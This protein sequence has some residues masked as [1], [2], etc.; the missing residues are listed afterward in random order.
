MDLEFL[1]VRDAARRLHVHEN[2]VRNMVDRGELQDYR[3]PGSRFMRLSADEVDQLAAMRT[4]PNSSILSRRRVLNPELVDAS[5]L[6]KWPETQQRDAQGKL[7]ELVRRLL[8]ETPGITNISIRSGDGIAQPGYDGTADSAGAAFLP[9]GRLVFEFSTNHNTSGK[10]TGDY[11]SRVENGS[12]SIADTFI[13]V[14]PRRWGGKTQWAAERKQQG[15][16]ADVKVIDADDLEGWLQTAPAAHHWISEELGLHPRDAISL[17][18]WW[19]RFAGQ[20]NPELPPDL[21]LA[22]RE[23]Q[24]MELRQRLT[25]SATVTAIEA[26]WDE[27]CLAFLHAAFADIQSGLAI[28]PALVVTSRQA[29]EDIVEQRGNA[30]LIQRFDDADVARATAAGHHV[31]SIIDNSA[32]SSRRP[33]ISLPKLGRGPVANALRSAG[34]E[35]SRA[36]RLAALSR[37]SLPALRRELSPN[38][39]ISRPDWSRAPDGPILAALLL[40]GQWT[41]DPADIETLEALTGHP[42]EK[43]GLLFQRMTDSEDPVL[44]KVSGI[45]S[46]AWPEESF[47]LLQPSITDN[48]LRRFGEISVREL[49]EPS[50]PDKGRADGTLNHPRKTCLRRGLAQGLALLGAFGARSHLKDGTTAS[51]FAEHTVDELLA[52]AHEDDTGE[53]WQRLAEVLPLLAEAAPDVFAEVLED[54]L[55]ATESSLARLFAGQS[56]SRFKVESSLARNHLLWALETICW[57]ADHLV[58]GVRAL[59]RIASLDPGDRSSNRPADSLRSILTGYTRHTNASL[60]E[61]FQALDAAYRVAPQVAWKLN[62]DLWPGNNRL[63]FPPARPR[64]RDWKPDSSDVD[65]AECI[66]FTDRL[67]DLA[68]V[69]AGADGSRVGQLANG[70]S[71]VPTKDQERIIGH[72]STF[73]SSELLDD[74]SRF[75]LWEQLRALVERQRRFASADSAL[76]A[77]TVDRIGDLV[78]ALEQ[79]PDPRR[80]AYLFDWS[81]DLA[82]V[83]QQNY[84]AYQAELTRLRTEALQS[85]LGMV[86][87][88]DELASL[89]RRVPSPELLGSTL[90]ALDGVELPQMIPWLISTD[91]PLVAASSAWVGRRLDVAGENWLSSALLVPELQKRARELL[92]RRVPPTRAMWSSLRENSADEEVYWRLASFET[93][94]LASADAG[95]ALE[96]LVRHQRPW[97]ALVVA[98]NAIGHANFE[99]IADV[100]SA[101]E[102]E[103]I[104]FLPAQKILDLFDA[105]LKDPSMSNE[106]SEMVGFHIGQLID[107]LAQ[108]SAY[109]DRIAFYEFAFF[110]LLEQ[111]RQPRALHRALATKPE[112]FVKLVTLAY[113]GRHESRRA[114]T[115]S[116]PNV[117]SVAAEVLEGWRGFPGCREDRSL[118]AE[119][120]QSWVRAARLAFSENDRFDIGDELIGQSLARSPVG[121]DGAWPSAP[122]R[123]LLETTGS[124]YL[125]RGL[126]VGRINSRRITWRGV[127]EGGRQESDLEDQY[128]QWARLISPSWPRAASV[129]KKLARWYQRDARQYDLEAELS[130][131]EIF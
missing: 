50:P 41:E 83:N 26:P 94:V 118:D 78:S 55:R 113:R 13:F 16:Y 18:R 109:E 21:F 52:R 39:R 96:Q 114:Q 86:A 3:L 90:G 71:S 70:I 56:D 10:A 28:P 6:H 77:K 36:D 60:D 69:N 58:D 48:L 68:I 34:V 47:H 33:D 129:L 111:Q 29:W 87:S 20:T 84:E 53:V 38:Q 44:H 54:D 122:V 101:S 93:V 42:E 115:E 62:M 74:E 1:K 79:Q 123:D 37:R 100:P 30:I 51:D 27:D 49:S 107:Y 25:S 116:E 128:L 63:I 5:Q 23:R 75:A 32:G 15:H 88:V 22:G 11:N 103:T 110:K 7:P 59:A 2:T 127:N 72:L 85:V 24:A 40:A 117:A 19:R 9:A 112:Q 64:F 91:A 31:I 131:D 12:A 124:P 46:F 99:A 14:T 105:A 120:M 17:D 66:D 8:E 126:V 130:S 61:K 119:L 67:V 108:D 81:P 89:A 98:S 45:W 65:F 4:K 102:V 97:S 104:D 106:R 57:S 92:L 73:M 82:G 43:L 80:F 76:P 121:D 35:F 125:E 95:E